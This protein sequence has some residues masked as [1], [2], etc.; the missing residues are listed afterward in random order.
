MTTYN[1]SEDIHANYN[2][3]KDFKKLLIDS[4][5][6]DEIPLF[7]PLQKAT[8]RVYRKKEYYEALGI[9]SPYLYLSILGFTYLGGYIS[10]KKQFIPGLDYFKNHNFDFVGGRKPIIM[11]FIFGLSFGIY[12]FGNNNLFYENARA[13]K[14]YYKNLPLLERSDE[15]GRF[16]QRRK[17]TDYSP[18]DD[19]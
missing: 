18:Y 16:K 9:K 11:G 4:Q 13:I 3:K 6:K 12:M 7:N 1:F 19:L 5:V 10:A 8:I 14:W 15:T 17:L 2:L